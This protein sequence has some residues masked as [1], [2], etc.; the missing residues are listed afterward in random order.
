M[1]F[2]PFIPCSR[3]SGLH[4]DIGGVEEAQWF[5]SKFERPQKDF[6][7]DFGGNPWVMPPEAVVENGRSAIKTYYTDVQ[8]AIEAGATVTSRRLLKVVLVGS[9]SAGKTR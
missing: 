2:T 5:L 9:S 1:Y 4:E 3:L 6:E 7:F 8:M